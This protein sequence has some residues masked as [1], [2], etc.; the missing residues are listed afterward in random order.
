MSP[1]KKSQGTPRVV[2]TVLGE[3]SK[4]GVRDL[5]RLL[6]TPF[7]GDAVTA[8]LEETPGEALQH[9]TRPGW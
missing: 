5:A 4:H 7:Q 8:V 6:L 2:Q 1:L 9:R 3:P